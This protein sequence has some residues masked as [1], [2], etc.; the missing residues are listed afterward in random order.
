MKLIFDFDYTLAD[1]SSGSVECI[2]YAIKKMGYALPSTK[3][4]KATIGL[5]LKH[6]FFSLVKSNS[7]IKANEFSRLF[8]ERA[9]Q[10][11]AEKTILFDGVIQLFNKMKKYDIRYAIVSTKYRYRIQDILKR[12][13]LDKYPDIIIGGED[14]ANH[15][16][17]PDGIFKVLKYWDSSKNEVIFIGDSITDAKTARNANVSFRAILSGVTSLNDF[18]EYKVDKFYDGIFQLI[19]DKEIFQQF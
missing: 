15:K 12:N 13:N 7:T 11:M 5:S 16:P 2:N 9:D 1:S 4:A 17:A 14:V 8:V 18:A 19:N 10:V 3:K 6:T